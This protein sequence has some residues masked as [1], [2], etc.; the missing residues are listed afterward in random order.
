MKYAI[1]QTGGKQYRVS[2]GDVLEVDRLK[3]EKNG[4]VVFNEVLLLV[5]EDNKAKFGKPFVS[6]ESV[7]ATLVENTRGEKIRVSKFK[8]KVRYRKVTGFRADLSKIKIE[9]IGGSK[10]A[11]KKS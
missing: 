5:S 7:E 2:E 8:S 11:A 6:G 10:S 1:I 3:A 9:K 4:K